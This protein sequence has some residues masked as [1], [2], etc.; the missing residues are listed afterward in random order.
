MNWKIFVFFKRAF[1][2]WKF[3]QLVCSLLPGFAGSLQDLRLVRAHMRLLAPNTHTH[4]SAANHEKTMD[5]L[6]DMGARLAEE[7]AEVMADLES[8]ALTPRGGGGDGGGPLN[9]P[10]C[11]I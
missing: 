3:F 9:P 4:V 1:R 5:S 6:R 8:G 11:Q 7:T 10:R 2:K